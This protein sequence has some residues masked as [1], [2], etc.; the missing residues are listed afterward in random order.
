MV[1]LAHTGGLVLVLCC[2][3]FSFG[4]EALIS[5]NHWL[6]SVRVTPYGT[7]RHRVRRIPGPGRLITERIVDILVGVLLG[8]AA[9]LAVPDRPRQRVVRTEP[10]GPRTLAATGRSQGPHPDQ[11]TGDTTEGVRP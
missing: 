8:L 6:G 10:P 11:R 3:A 4:A 5:R 1:P 9:A 7:A 2:L